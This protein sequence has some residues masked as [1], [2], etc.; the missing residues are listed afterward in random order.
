MSEEKQ[1][2]LSDLPQAPE[3]SVFT[4]EKVEKL[5]VPHPYCITP[6]HV[7]HAAD[8]FSGRLGDEAIKSA[9]RDGAH[10]DI[11]KGKYPYE[12]HEAVNSLI[13]RVPQNKDLN[14]VPGL[15]A[16]LLANKQAFIDA[17]IDGFA[18]PETK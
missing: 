16:W 9:E 6:R 1:I 5:S 10:C 11:C 14:A 4:I 18:F 2:S 17:G 13:I 3:G 8:K 12:K 7:A 15:H